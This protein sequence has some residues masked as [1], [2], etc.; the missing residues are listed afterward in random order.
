MVRTLRV[1]NSLQWILPLLEE[2]AGHCGGAVAARVQ[3]GLEE[4]SH[5]EGQERRR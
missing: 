1:L 3:K 4:L 5:V 2:V